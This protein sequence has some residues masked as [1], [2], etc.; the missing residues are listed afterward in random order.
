MRNRKLIAVV[1]FIF[2]LLFFAACGDDGGNESSENENDAPSDSLNAGDD[3]NLED[4]LV[5]D[6]IIRTSPSGITLECLVVRD[7]YS[8]YYDRPLTMFCVDS[9]PPIG[10]Q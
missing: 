7:N 4:D 8:N 2:A 3:N 1:L 6:W 5:T 10:D 9:S